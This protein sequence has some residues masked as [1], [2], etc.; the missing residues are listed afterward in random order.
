MFILFLNWQK[1][2]ERKTRNHSEL[3]GTN[4]QSSPELGKK[5]VTTT[6][7][8][9]F[10]LF[11]MTPSNENLHRLSS[12]PIYE[13]CLQSFKVA[14]LKWRICISDTSKWNVNMQQQSIN[15]Q[16]T[17]SRTYTP[18]NS[19]LSP[20]DQNHKVA[21]LLSKLGINCRAVWSLSFPY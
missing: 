1:R 10:N 20:L 4:D 9:V 13:R 2:T 14:T 7:W 19:H 12:Q 8:Q 15:T 16:N 3:K 6:I 11:T 17:I 18:A 21:N 5:I